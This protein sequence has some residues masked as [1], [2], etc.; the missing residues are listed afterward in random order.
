[1]DGIFTILVLFGIFSSI[2]KW[3]KKQQGNGQQ[4][5][6]K[7]PDQPWKRML[8]DV[9]KQLEDTMSG[10]TP[11]QPAKLPPTIYRPAPASQNEGARGSEGQHLSNES[12]SSIPYLIG[13][14]GAGSPYALSS[15]GISKPLDPLPAWRGSLTGTLDAAYSSNEADIRAAAEQ[16]QESN[17]TLRLNFDQDSLVSA[18][19]MQEILTRPQD[20]K[21]RWSTH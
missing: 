17:P 8:G 10:K 18:I 15:E 13:G 6:G 4:G 12:G 21:R 20:R 9:A 3:V 19:V 11:M 1:M 16:L 14:E 5:S 2:A 7:V